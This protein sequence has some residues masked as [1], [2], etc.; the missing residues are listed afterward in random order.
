[1]PVKISDLATATTSWD[2]TQVASGAY[3]VAYDLWI[4]STPTT[5][6]QPDGTDVMIWLNS[7]GG[8]QPFG[9]KTASASIA[10]KQWDVWTG[11]QA[12]WKIVS[13]VLAPGPPR[14]PTWTPRR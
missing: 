11:Q 7:R 10:G 8:V 6:G 1:M 13:Y 5:T 12:S 3:D 2:T 4:N 9:A 14:S